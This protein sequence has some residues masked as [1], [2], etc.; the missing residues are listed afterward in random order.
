MPR[1]LAL[2]PLLLLA[3][4]AACGD[5]D[6]PSASPSATGGLTPSPSPVRVSLPLIVD[7]SEIYLQ[8]TDGSDPTLIGSFPPYARLD[9]SPVGDLAVVSRWGSALSK[10]D[11]L[12]PPGWKGETISVDGEVD[13]VSWSPDGE[14]LAFRRS[15]ADETAIVV[16]GRDGSTQNDLRSFGQGVTL[17]PAGWLSAAHLL[18]VQ[19]SGRLADFD[20]VSGNVAEISAAT[21][22]ADWLFQP[23]I[24]PDGSLIAAATL[25]DPSCPEGA[26]AVSLVDVETGQ[27]GYVANG[28]CGVKALSWS[29][30]GA[31]LAF[32]VIPFPLD[33]SSGV[34]V[35][36]MGVGEPRAPLQ[37]V[38]DRFVTEV[39]W[40]PDGQTVF[41]SAVPCWGC[42]AGTQT[43]V[44]VPAAGGTVRELA[45]GSSTALSLEAGSLAF[46]ADNVVSLVD[47][48]TGG[49]EPL[50]PADGDCQI[51][52]MAW[53]PRGGT[54]AIALSHAFGT[55]AY[56]ASL[57]GS[58]LD[59]LTTADTSQATFIAPDQSR[60][61]VID[62]EAGSREGPLS[63]MLGDGSGRVEAPL[64]GVSTV[65]WAPDGSKLIA[66][67][68][69]PDSFGGRKYFIIGADGSVLLDLGP[70]D[71]YFFVQGGRWS[72][73]GTKFAYSGEKLSIADTTSGQ[74]IQA[75][76]PPLSP[77][78][79]SWTTDSSRVVFMAAGEIYSVAADGAGLRKLTSEGAGKTS[80]AL[81][82]D[83]RTL[84]YRRGSVVGGLEEVVLHDLETGDLTTLFDGQLDGAGPDEPI[85]WSPDGEHVA[86]FEAAASGWGIYLANAD[87]SGLTHWAYTASVTE[88]YWLDAE[89]LVF[90]TELQ[91]L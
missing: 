78:A 12:H 1:L 83:G 27:A 91:G 25:D 44:A 57:D 62:Y 81:S 82:P 90:T 29:P 68:P 56:V 45:T 43:W 34:F 3:L 11:F 87:G 6:G 69:R 16:V 31:R 76:G 15:S 13:H 9:W 33:G 18:V 86:F 63:I 80:P 35:L 46:A 58:T 47:V 48:D 70:Q 85:A 40:S 65:K 5:D 52:Q 61:A 73:D 4:A 67:A 89:T 88:L 17:I 32:S 30:D 24:S 71:A 66:D 19:P 28:Y 23:A 42:D 55:R 54:L 77:R 72:P 14:R 51:G 41:G 38:A 21:V 8:D 59:R 50:W 7:P 26:D 39:R 36:D 22:T 20:V 49:I 10:I 37:L 84:V 64:A 60:I 79:I 75:T 53:E 2:S 74:V